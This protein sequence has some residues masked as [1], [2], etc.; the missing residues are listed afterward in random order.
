MGYRVEGDRKPFF[1]QVVAVAA[2]NLENAQ[3]FAK[4]HS[5]SRVHGSYE[6][7]AADPDV[8]QCMKYK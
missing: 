8:G 4:T 7:L 2:R 1:S 6:E 5:I 3:E